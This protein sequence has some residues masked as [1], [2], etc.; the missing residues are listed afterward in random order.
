VEPTSRRSEPTNAMG[1]SRGSRLLVGQAKAVARTTMN[2]ASDRHAVKNG[3]SVWLLR[4]HSS[5]DR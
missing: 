2:P 3:R 1:T 4:R 5:G